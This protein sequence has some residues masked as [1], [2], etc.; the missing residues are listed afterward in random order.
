MTGRLIKE[1]GEILSVDESAAADVVSRREADAAMRERMLESARSNAA[2]WR[3]MSRAL[4]RIND[5]V[6]R[7]R[8]SSSEL[9][10]RRQ[11]LR[12][13][14]VCPCVCVF[15]MSFGGYCAVVSCGRGEVHQQYSGRTYIYIYIFH[16]N[17]ACQ[18]NMP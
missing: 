8:D 5:A 13:V 18:Q 16:E 12:C 17:L 15:C 10:A 6:R 2:L 9:E 3:D 1:R 4:E 7:V 11:E 14:S